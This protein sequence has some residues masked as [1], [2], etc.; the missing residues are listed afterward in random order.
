[1]SSDILL[2][3]VTETVKSLQS[4][5]FG[6]DAVKSKDELQSLIVKQQVRL[7]ALRRQ[8]ELAIKLRN[9][10]PERIEKIEKKSSEIQ[11]S[12]VQLARQEESQKAAIANIKAR[13]AELG[14][15]VM[16]IANLIAQSREQTALE[17][18]H[19]DN[20]WYLIGRVVEMRK[21]IAAS[22]RPGTESREGDFDY[23]T[24][25]I[26]HNE[27]LIREIESLLH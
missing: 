13:Q 2:E 25:R 17:K 1:M 10:L 3:E 27:K 4:S 12:I 7:A 19:K 11:E 24:S 21:D 15:Q 6:T 14:K 8:Q 20:C 5:P 26:E 23:L 22:S 16:D 9:E 18:F